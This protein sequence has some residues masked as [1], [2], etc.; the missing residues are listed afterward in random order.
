MTTRIAEATAP[1]DWSEHFTPERV[2]QLSE[3]SAPALAELQQQGGRR[4]LDAQRRVEALEKRNLASLTPAELSEHR[5]AVHQA[6]LELKQSKDQAALVE[7]A[8]KVAK[9]RERDEEGV[10]DAAAAAE[11]LPRLLES[12]ERAWAAFE[13]ARTALHLGVSRLFD[14]EVRS[15]LPADPTFGLRG[16][17]L[18]ICPTE[19]RLVDLDREGQSLVAPRERWPRLVSE[20]GGGA[21][22]EG[23]EN[24]KDADDFEAWMEARQLSRQ[25]IPATSTASRQLGE[26]QNRFARRPGTGGTP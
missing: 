18:K 7:R 23:I 4:T 9:K 26:L 11:V 21:H 2:D 17:I 25:Q 12:A 24:L 13:S 6:E 22:F 15:R 10:R 3:K 19:N 1:A 8:H 14:A 20:V 5:G 16:R